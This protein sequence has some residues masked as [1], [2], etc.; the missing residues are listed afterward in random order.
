VSEIYDNVR[1]G[2]VDSAQSGA[3]SCGPKSQFDHDICLLRD[4]ANARIL[5]RM[6]EPQIR[7]TPSREISYIKE[8][9]LHRDFLQQLRW[10]AGHF[11]LS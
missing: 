6:A 7:Q 5:P 10:F 9:P 3:L 1:A 4:T 11:T 8:Y 2:I